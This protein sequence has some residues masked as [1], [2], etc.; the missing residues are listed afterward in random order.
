MVFFILSPLRKDQAP[1]L[2]VQRVEL[3]DIEGTYS[4]ITHARFENIQHQY[5]YSTP[6]LNGLCSVLHQA[7]LI[8]MGQHHPMYSSSAD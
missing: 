1:V 5:L 4:Y 8:R 7:I 6:P 2:A 3:G